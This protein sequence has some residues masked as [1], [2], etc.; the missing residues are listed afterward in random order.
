[1]NRA[2]RGV[3]DGK[4]APSEHTLTCHLPFPALGDKHSIYANC[5]QSF[6]DLHTCAGKWGY[7]EHILE[8]QGPEPSGKHL[9]AKEPGERADL[10]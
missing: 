9:C 2:G 1:M 3:P 5:L 8:K 10:Q 4:G 7:S 6:L